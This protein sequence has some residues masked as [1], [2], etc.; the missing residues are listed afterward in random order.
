MIP[1]VL[2]VFGSMVVLDFIWAHYTLFL[3]KK[4]AAGAGLAATAIM[5][6]NAVVTIGYVDDHWM[7]IPTAVG[8]FV[9]TYA[10]IKLPLP[11]LR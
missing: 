2:Y 5:L 3:L 8:A 6:C 10:A 7:I 11:W 4:K 1:Q 9:G